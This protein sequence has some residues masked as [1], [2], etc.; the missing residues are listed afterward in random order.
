MDDNQELVRSDVQH[1]VDQLLQTDS[2]EQQKKVAL[3]TLSLKE[4][5]G[6]SESAVNFVIGEVQQVFGHTIGRVKAG[7]N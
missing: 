1:A 2:I 5:C 4:V 6:L 3:F 7:V